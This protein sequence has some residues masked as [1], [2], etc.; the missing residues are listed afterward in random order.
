MVITPIYFPLR[1]GLCINSVHSEQ[2]SSLLHCILCC[3]KELASFSHTPATGNYYKNLIF[4]EVIFDL[5]CI[6]QITQICGCHKQDSELTDSG[7]TSS[8]IHSKN[9]RYFCPLP[10]IWVFT[11]S[12]NFSPSADLENFETA[13]N[14]LK[15]SSDY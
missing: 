7:I 10:W 6:R 11:C 15:F 14:V 12:F 9:A 8:S 5:E 3:S 2:T 4:S 13:L 1:K